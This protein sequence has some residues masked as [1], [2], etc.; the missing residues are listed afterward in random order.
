MDDQKEGDPARKEEPAQ[1]NPPPPIPPQNHAVLSSA[2]E[3]PRENNVNVSVNLPSGSRP[4]E[5]FQLGLNAVLAIIG[6]LAVCIYGGQLNTMKGQL[7]AA[8]KQLTE[9]EKQYPELQKSA[10]AAKDSADT[11]EEALVSVQRAFIVVT[12]QDVVGIGFGNSQQSIVKF[13]WENTGVTPG[14]DLTTHVSFMQPDRPLSAKYTFPDLWGPTEP[15]IIVRG[16]IAP[17][18]I[19]QNVIGMIPKA[20]IV[21]LKEAPIY[22]WGW[23]RYRDIFN[24]TPEHITE[25][26]TELIGFLGDPF[27]GPG[28]VEPATTSCPF[29]NCTDEEYKQAN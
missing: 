18:G 29:H 20:M 11:A 10:K 2:E 6:I 15:H 23:A 26:C 13:T 7:T 5:W 12:K 8:N 19:R 16:P 4:I 28:P 22:F 27:S 3:N 21:K 1:P 17:H 24:N 14:I 25:Y 9:I